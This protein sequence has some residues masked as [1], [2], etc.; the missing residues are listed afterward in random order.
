[1]DSA[2][3]IPCRHPWPLSHGDTSV[4]RCFHLVAVADLIQSRV[5][6]GNPMVSGP[7]TTAAASHPEAAT[8]LDSSTSSTMTSSFSGLSSSGKTYLGVILIV[9]IFVVSCVSLHI[10][11]CHGHTLAPLCLLQQC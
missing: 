8:V 10:D 9:C 11:R 1:M 2:A 7:A 3:V 4:A 5:A 6:T